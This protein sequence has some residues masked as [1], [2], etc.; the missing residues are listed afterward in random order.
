LRTTATLGDGVI[1]SNGTQLAGHVM[2]EDRATISGLC[3]GAS[4]RPHRPHAFVGGCSRVAQDVPPYVKAVGNPV[5]LFGLNSGDCSA[6]ASP[7]RS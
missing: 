1:I 3:A 5:K 6:A 4:V 7:N 2:V